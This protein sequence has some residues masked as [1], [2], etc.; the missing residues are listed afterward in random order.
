[1]I[2]LFADA[3]L[4]KEE[5]RRLR[6]GDLDQAARLVTV[7]AGKGG[8]DGLTFFEESTALAEANQRLQ[9]DLL[10]VGSL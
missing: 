6:I 2:G 10:R 5:L 7:R 1:M 4:R 9:R 8:R 3:A